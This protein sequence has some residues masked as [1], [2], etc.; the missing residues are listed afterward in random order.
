[1]G[2]KARVRKTQ[3]RSRA[4]QQRHQAHS[5]SRSPSCSI[6]LLQ[7]FY[8]IITLQHHP[9][10]LVSAK[11]VRL[12]RASNGD[13]VGAPTWRML[14]FIRTTDALKVQILSCDMSCH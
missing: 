10:E 1:M 13:W 6:G 9:Y 2:V 12:K 7:L 8:P 4:G 5:N 3:R 14:P 11:L